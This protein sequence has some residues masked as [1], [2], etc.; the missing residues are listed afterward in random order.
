MGSHNVRSEG[1]DLILPAPK[2]FLLGLQHVLVLYV[3]AVA[4]PLVLGA[5]LGL[6]QQQ[7]AFLINADLMTSGFATIVQAL[8]MGRYF[9][10]RMPLMQGCTL[11]FVGF[12]V[13]I[14]TEFNIQTMYGSIIAAGV[15]CALLAPFFGRLM[16]YFP[17]VVRGSLITLVGLSLL[18]VAVN[19]ITNSSQNTSMLVNIVL[20]AFVVGIIVII[21]KYLQGF[22]ANISVLIALVCGFI[23]AF[24]LGVVEPA[25]LE[26]VRNAA[27]LGINVPFNFGLPQ[28]NFAAI[29]SACTIMS[30]VMAETMV[31]YLAIG[32]ITDK[33]LTNRDITN[34]LRAEGLNTVLGAVFNA[35]PYT[36]FTQNI[37]LIALTGVTSRYVVAVGGL[38]LIILGLF[39]KMAT[40]IAAVPYPVLG[41]VGIAVFSTIAANGIKSLRQVDL[42]MPKNTFIIS[43]TIGVGLTCTLLKGVGAFYLF[44]DSLRIILEDGI[45]VGCLVAIILNL[46]YQDKQQI[47]AITK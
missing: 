13:T 27:W 17:L 8:G 3:G 37:G 35:F 9:G 21:T 26:A 30:V 34:G 16:K 1:I 12:L 29:L 22:W 20:A 38:I 33:E 47:E 44:P 40:L 11:M 14:G 43:L 6:S 18:P 46:F 7:I 4:V 2:M 39:P 45:V 25:R 31:V 23:F 32:E 36:S 10:I 19:W 5:A 41:G 28:F 42:S 15:F 24:V